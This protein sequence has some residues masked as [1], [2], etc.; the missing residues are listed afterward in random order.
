MNDETLA[1][2]TE[3]TIYQDIKSSLDQFKEETK[4]ELREEIK[5]AFRKTYSVPATPKEDNG[6]LVEWLSAVGQT[7]RPYTREKGFNTLVNKYGWKAMT[8]GTNEAGGFTVPEIWANELL[9]IETYESVAFPNRVRVV[10]MQT[11]TQ[12]YPVYDQTVTPSNGSSAFN[13]GLSV[14]IVSEANAPGAETKPAFKQVSLTAS[15]VLAYTEVANE[16]IDNSA[17]SIDSILREG[18]Q[19]AVIDFV[20]YNIFNGSDLTGIIGH[21]SCVNVFRNT[22]NDFKYVDAAKMISRHVGKNKLWVIHP[23]HWENLLNFQSTLGQLVYVQTANGAVIPTLFG[24]PVMQ[25]Q[26]LPSVG[27]E[28]D[29]CLVDLDK[30]LLGVNKSITVDAS[31]HYK[32]TSDLTVYRVTM[33]LA[34]KPILTA[35]IK[36]AD[37]TSTVSP[38]VTLDNALS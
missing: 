24:Y 9:K 1:Q 3:Q 27:S 20:D 6:S 36:L 12:K 13:A 18:L 26:F 25:S 22:A 16:L 37:G 28:G 8:Q 29:V 34:G 23:Y 15:K 31:P 17:L 7:A 2:E 30:Y 19:Q 35:P 11:D 5:T 38:F 32:F 10:P 4:N 14:A 21:A 33:R